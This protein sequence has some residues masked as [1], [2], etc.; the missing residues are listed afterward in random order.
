[1]WRGRAAF[2]AILGLIALFCGAVSWIRRDIRRLRGSHGELPP[3]ER[4]AA[5]IMIVIQ[6]IV[7]IASALLVAFLLYWFIG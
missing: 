5:I 6:I 2:W 4:R 1:M 3:H 7:A